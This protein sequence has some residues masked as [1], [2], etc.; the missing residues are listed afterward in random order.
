[1]AAPQKKHSKVNLNVNLLFPQG[2]PQKLPVRFLKWLISYGRFIAI[3]VEVI[4]ISAFVLRFKFD[5]DLSDINDKINEQIPFIESL[6]ADEAAIKQT[7]FKLSTIRGVYSTT[8]SW[9]SLLDEISKQIPSGV[10]LTS[11]GLDHTQQVKSVTFR[12]SGVSTTNRD[13]AS[14]VAGLKADTA[15]KDIILSSISFDQGQ[16]NFTISGGST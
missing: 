3:F 15:L 16:I 5:Q 2:V 7:Q 13:L 11:I 4:V 6:S 1:M 9:N 8:P 14:F 10:K 12:L